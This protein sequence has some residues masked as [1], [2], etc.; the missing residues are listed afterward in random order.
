[1]DVSSSEALPKVDL[2]NSTNVDKIY[3]AR[4]ALIAEEKKQRS[5]KS[6]TCPHLKPLPNISRLRIPSISL[7]NRSAS[8]LYSLANPRGREKHHL[9]NR[10]ES[11]A[12]P[13][14]AI[15]RDDV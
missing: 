2:G 15:P 5:G 11:R 12:E 7:A 14:R 1:M 10:R 13:R 8:M 3:A 4:N 9:E 6:L